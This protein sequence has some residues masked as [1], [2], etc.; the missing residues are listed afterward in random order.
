MVEG[1]AKKMSVMIFLMAVFIMLLVMT[2][3]WIYRMY[4][5]QTSFAQARTLAAI[6]C[7]NYYFDI[8]ET[9][10]TYDGEILYFEIKNTLGGKI[11]TIIVESGPSKV[12]VDIGLTS[13]TT[14]PVSIPFELYGTS[15]MIYP[16]GCEDVNF[17]NVSFEPNIGEE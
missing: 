4:S 7:G 6:E 15:L 12:S 3:A 16:E 11:E 13:G 8:D 9:T 1:R 17:K 14:Y 2:G 5:E 10:V